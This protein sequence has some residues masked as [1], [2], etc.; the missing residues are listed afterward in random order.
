[1]ALKKSSD[2]QPNSGELMKLLL[3]SGK[4]SEQCGKMLMDACLSQMEDPAR[5]YKFFVGVFQQIE[6]LKPSAE[7]EKLKAK[8][9]QALVE[10]EQGPLRP[11]TFVGQVPFNM[12]GPGPRLEVATPDGQLRYPSVANSL[13]ESELSSGCTVFLDPQ[14]AVVVASDPHVPSIGQEAKFLRRV[15]GTNSVEIQVRDE[16][17]VLHASQ[18]LLDAIDADQAKRGDAI[19]FCP[20]REFA[21]CA[22]PADDDHRHRFVN[23]ASIPDVIPSRDI[24]RPHWSLAWLMRRT[25]LL[26]N[27]P[28]LLE[29]FQ[30]RPRVSLLMLGPPGTGKTLTIRAFLRG[31]HDK[32]VERTGRTDIESRA[33]RVKTGDLLSP[34]FGE[35]DQNIDR[36]FDN[37]IE[38]AS[39]RE[40]TASGEE[41][42]LPIVVIFEECE[43]LA[44]RRG[45]DDGGAVYD[46]VIGTLLQRLDDPTDDLARL[47][48]IIIATSNRPDMLD[49]GMWRRLAGMVAHFKRLDR[50]GLHA[51]LR[52]KIRP[53]LPLTSNNGHAPEE[54]RTSLIDRIVAALYSPN[55]D[56]GLVEIVLRDGAKLVKGRRHFLTGA[57]VEQAVSEAIDRV[58]FAVADSEADGQGLSAEL[59]LDALCRQVDNLADNVTARNAREFLDL[60]EHAHIADVRRLR[61]SR[62]HAGASLAET[63]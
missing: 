40:R 17:V 34:W 19:V 11:A 50:D 37:L 55:A 31:F 13:K 27:R 20:R 39:R 62:G 4:S 18:H 12:P 43:A 16:R 51:V 8:Y 54:L 63:N 61:M 57:L 30:L 52:K 15:P 25:H 33:I 23:T 22:V 44:R 3:A 21:F 24:G 14:G 42:L 49:S 36:L 38:I 41:L 59:V 47:P 1:M 9:E 48:L 46:R 26:L 5:M 56:E 2:S 35:T 32:L 6:H 58:A 28:D 60:P 45:D 7:A 10:L 53:T 29:R